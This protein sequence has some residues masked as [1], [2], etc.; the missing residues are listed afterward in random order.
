MYAM[1]NIQVECISS[2]N[3]SDGSMYVSSR[4]EWSSAVQFFLA[5]KYNCRPS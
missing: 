2:G 1:R 5:F 3:G 4:G